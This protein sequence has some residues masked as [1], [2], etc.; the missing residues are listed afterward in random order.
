MVDSIEFKVG[1]VTLSSIVFFIWMIVFVSDNNP[2]EK[3]DF[4]N[5]TFSDAGLLQKGDQVRLNGIP[6]GKVESIGLSNS[7]KVQV[8]FSID[9]SIKLR[10]DTKIIVGD[11]GL[12]GTN[13][14]KV[15]QHYTS[16]NPEVWDPG[17]TITGSQE[18]GFEEL[19]N[20]GHELV[21]Q[22]KHTFASLN[23]IISDEGIHKDVKGI[24]SDLKASTDKTKTM[25]DS[26][27]IKINST[28]DDVNSITT[29]LKYDAESSGNAVIEAMN[30]LNGILSDLD[31]ISSRNSKNID[32]AVHNIT[33]M[34]SS[35]EA[36]GNT[37]ED[38]KTLIRNLKDVSDTL[39]D[40]AHDVSNGGTTA[41]KIKSI[42]AK[43]ETVTDDLAAM[44][45]EVKEF[46]LDPETKED[47]RQAFNDVNSLATN[48]DS[49]TSKINDIKFKLQAAVYY[50]EK[51]SDYRSDFWGQIEGSRFLFRLGFEDVKENSS[52]NTIQVGMKFNSLTLRT[53]LIQDEF[54]IGSD[55]PFGSSDAFRLT[56]EGF[57]PDKFT[58][59][60]MGSF[61]VY[62]GTRVAVWHQ[63]NK[64]E[65]I[66]Y[67]GIQQEF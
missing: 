34:V 26:M 30:K 45:G 41:A 37:V 36:E 52:I 16:K 42:T 25:F 12:F 49:T 59:R 1:L 53:G 29:T 18:P 21:V 55:I 17:S 63:R 9:A 67:S 35:L 2:L 65:S 23:Q 6:I 46:V 13:Y 43:A 22:L 62:K 27:E 39:K 54:G 7:G 14:I 31:A 33:S 10:K 11:V 64:D 3:K 28:L 38:V 50:G 51:V 15:S 47:I 5:V 44:T 24:F 19:L 40:F 56:L 66:T 61:K 57:N 20:E 4:Y 48:I 32:K 60:A 8:G 58:W